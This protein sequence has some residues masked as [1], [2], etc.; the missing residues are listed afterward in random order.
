VIERVEALQLRRSCDGARY[1]QPTGRSRSATALAAAGLLR[2]RRGIQRVLVIA[3][4]SVKYQWETEIERF[5]DHS[6]Q[7][8]DGLLPRRRTLY[9]APAFFNLTS[10]H[11]HVWRAG[12]ANYYL[13]PFWC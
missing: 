9:A 3:P 11:G 12:P 7:V 5:T 8:I 13:P 6:A 10:C 1:S 2:R 4:A